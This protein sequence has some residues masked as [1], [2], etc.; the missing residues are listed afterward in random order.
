MVL[1]AGVGCDTH[2]HGVAI[3]HTVGGIAAYAVVERGCSRK[4]ELQD[5]GAVADIE[6]VGKNLCCSNGVDRY[7]ESSVVVA[8]VSRCYNRGYKSLGHSLTHIGIVVPSG[9]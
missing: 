2:T 1:R 7:C 8:V 5:S 4:V 6:G 3:G 9:A